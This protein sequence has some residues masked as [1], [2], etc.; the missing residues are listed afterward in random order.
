[1]DSMDSFFSFVGVLV[2][3]VAVMT[4]AYKGIGI[5]L[6]VWAKASSS[7]VGGTLTRRD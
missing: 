1:M 4:V 6:G 5:F 2:C 7:P 3:A